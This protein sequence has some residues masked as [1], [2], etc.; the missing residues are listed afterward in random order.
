M[1]IFNLLT[2]FGGLAMFF[3]GME[4]MGDGLKKSSGETLKRILGRLTKNVFAGMLTGMVVTAIIQSSSATI[5]LSV[6]LM[7]AGILTLRQAISIVMGAN[8]GTT[9]TAQIIRLMDIDSS[10]NALLEFLKPSS[11][12]P[13]A[14]IIGIILIMFVRKHGTKGIGE[15]FMGFGILFIGLLTMTSAVSPLAESPVFI[16]ILQRFSQ[17][18]LLG[19]VTG[20]VIT[21]IV[22]SSSAVVGMLQ[23]LSSTGTMTFSLIYP[24]I[25]GIN[26]GTCIV[27]AVL[28]SIGSSRDAKRTAVAHILF[29]VIG[30]VLFMI[31]MTVV[32]KLGGFGEL[33]MKTVDSGDIANF[34]TLF[35]VITAAVLMPFTG[36][37]VKLSCRIIKADDDENERAA[38]AGLLDEKLL[39]SP[40]VAMDESVRAIARMGTL[41]YDNLNLSVA[42]LI[43]YNPSTSEAIHNREERIDGFADRADN[44]L[45]A[46]SKKLDGG[47]SDAQMNLLMQAVPDFERIGD[48]ATNI[49]ELALRLQAGKVSFS[50]NG[51]AEL[52]VICEAVSEIVRLTVDAFGANDLVLAAKVEPLEE[53]IDDIVQTLRDNHTDRLRQGT[54]TVSGGLVFLEVL[55]YLERAA[56]QCSSIALLMLAI[57]NKEIRVNHHAYLHELHAAGNT[58]YNAELER[59]RAQYLNRL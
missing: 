16:E 24:L 35:N 45:I 30:T 4:L 32:Q 49:D 57:D 20:I 43:T 27:T 56:D 15:I 50:D 3:Y 38:E 34:Q 39:V 59:R 29:N 10:G 36:I 1:T 51:K 44:F 19:I 25:L 28:C 52:S 42:Q 46:L 26:I 17:L 2:M 6:G 21:V 48:Y 18:P 9:V 55:T 5:V 54:C 58:E 12:A 37:L 31:G 40:G 53:V 23:A 47:G 41:A 11:L 22:Q 8:I 13:I 33:W 14:L 7:A